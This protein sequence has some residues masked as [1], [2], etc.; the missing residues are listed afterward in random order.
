MNQYTY[1]PLSQYIR[2]SSAVVQ[3]SDHMTFYSSSTGV[4]VQ[5][6]VGDPAMCFRL[7][8]KH[9]ALYEHCSIIA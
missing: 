2:V 5:A 6:A 9:N 3:V 7:R 4:P 8:K 1:V